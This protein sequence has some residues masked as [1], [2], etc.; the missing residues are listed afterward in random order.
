MPICFW[1]F[2]NSEVSF[3]ASAARLDAPPPSHCAKPVVQRREGVQRQHAGTSA[4]VADPLRDG[5]GLRRTRVPLRRIVAVLL[6]G[7]GDALTSF[8]MKSLCCLA[9]FAVDRNAVEG[10]LAEF[11]RIARRDQHLAAFLRASA[12]AGSHT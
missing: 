7:V 10:R 12:S 6:V 11:G 4:G 3:S 2:R 1:L 9:P 5:R 8:A